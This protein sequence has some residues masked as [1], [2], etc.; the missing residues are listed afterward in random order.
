M[1]LLVHMWVPTTHCFKAVWARSTQT[2]R[3][4]DRQANRQLNSKTDRITVIAH[5]TGTLRSESS[6]CENVAPRLDMNIAQIDRQTNLLQTERQTDK[7]V[8]RWVDR[9]VRS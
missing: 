3:Q 5:V 1:T 8:G 2:D 4:I 9:Y 7:H 6:P